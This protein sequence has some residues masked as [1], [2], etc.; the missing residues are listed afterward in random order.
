MVFFKVIVTTDRGQYAWD[1]WLEEAIPE[2]LLD[3]KLQDIR[4][5]SGDSPTHLEHLPTP[6]GTPGSSSNA[7]FGCYFCLPLQESMDS[8]YRKLEQSRQVQ[9]AL[10][11]FEARDRYLLEDNL[12]RV[13]FW[14]CITLFV[15]LAVGVTEVFTLRNLFDGP[16]RVRT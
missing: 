3:Y 12:W 5:R 16:R 15:L 2:Y 9:S 10:R 8:V 14:S 13:S 1:E 7:A 4:V 11:A 6:G